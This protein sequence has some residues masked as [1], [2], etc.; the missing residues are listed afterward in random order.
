MSIPLISRIA[1]TQDAAASPRVAASAAAVAPVLALVIAGDRT[2]ARLERVL[3]FAPG[4]WLF[5]L[6]L[7]RPFEQHVEERLHERIGCHDRV[8]VVHGPV[9]EG[10]CDVGRSL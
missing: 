3:V 9:L 6:W 10:E 1:R 2:P 5:R 4:T 8:G 7:R